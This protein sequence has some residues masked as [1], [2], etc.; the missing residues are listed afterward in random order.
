[1]SGPALLLD[2]HAWAW[3]L[4]AS[5]RLSRRAIACLTDAEA[6]FVS[7]ISFFEIGQK[8]CLR[9][10]PQ[11]EPFAERLPDLLREQ[12]GQTAALTAPICLD[13]ALLAWEHHDPFD[14]ILAAT[15]LALGLP[16]VSTDAAFDDLANDARWRGRLW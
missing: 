1:M 5:A 16:L 8:I 12:G 15:A 3:A 10:W 9:K 6:V 13:A 4:T 11:M 14:R 7:P 2:T